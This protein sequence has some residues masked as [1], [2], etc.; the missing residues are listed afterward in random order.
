[1]GRLD[2]T[3]ALAALCAVAAFG[4]FAWNP[5]TPDQSPPDPATLAPSQAL[6]L[7]PP[8]RR[9]GQLDCASRRCEQW[10]RVDVDR[11][12]MLRVEAQIEGLA[13]GA[14]ARLFLQDGTGETLAKA[15]SHDGHPLSVRAPVE[16]GPYAVLLQAGGGLVVW[17]LAAEL[18][19]E[20]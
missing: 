9:A 6:R 12:A 16:P 20:P 5:W 18:E 13:Q 11:S 2:L 4:C 3:A 8:E 1:M 14:I 7:R 17:S 15:T 19:G 10:I